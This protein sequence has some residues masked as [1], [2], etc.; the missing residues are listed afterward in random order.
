[1]N[2][3]WVLNFFYQ[4]TLKDRLWDYTYCLLALLRSLEHVFYVLIIAKILIVT[5][6]GKNDRSHSINDETEVHS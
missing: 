4:Y 3:Y 6:R 5:I 1:M 2:T